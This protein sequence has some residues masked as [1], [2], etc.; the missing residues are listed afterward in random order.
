MLFGWVGYKVAV[1]YSCL[2]NTPNPSPKHTCRGSCS[3][4][5]KARLQL[6]Y[7]QP[8]NFS[9]KLVLSSALLQ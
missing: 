9:V 7:E 2:E 5:G 1:V 3:S 4:V 8:L 6:G